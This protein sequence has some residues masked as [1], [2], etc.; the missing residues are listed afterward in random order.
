MQELVDSVNQIANNLQKDIFEITITLVSVLVPIILTIITIFLTKHIDKQNTELQINLSNR[1]THNQTREIFFMIYNAFLDGFYYVS[2]A[3]GNIPEIFVSDRSFYRW[4]L[5]LE[6]KN[7]EIAFS[8]N[9]AKLVSKNELLLKNLKDGFNIFSDLTN[10]VNSY[11]GSGLAYKICQNA[12]IQFS[13]N[14][15]NIQIGS[16]E[17]LLLNQELAEEFKKYCSNE[18]TDAIQNKIEK[19]T[20]IVG[21]DDFDEMF[22]KYT[23]V[24]EIE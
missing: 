19:Y 4:A 22:R 21:T 9:K 10:T 5:E 11:I 23:Q 12:W 15:P 2:Q 24:S 13:K 7:K 17:T 16:Y 14:H 20:M 1:D 6:N 18:Y 3:S 8:Y